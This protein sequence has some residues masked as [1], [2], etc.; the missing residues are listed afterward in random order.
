MPGL[1]EFASIHVR[2]LQISQHGSVAEQC[3]VQHIHKV[4]LLQAQIQAVAYIPALHE[5]QIAFSSH[6]Q[7]VL[8]TWQEQMDRVS[9]S[10]LGTEIF[11][12]HESWHLPHVARQKVTITSH[13]AQYASATI[14][15]QWICLGGS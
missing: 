8:S 6:P 7:A 2:R 3:G 5:Q 12:Q 10:S 1:L 4:R 15:R 11:H 13:L 14:S 9:S